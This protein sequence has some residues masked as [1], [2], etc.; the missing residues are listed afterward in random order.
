MERERERERECSRAGERANV[1][2]GKLWLTRHKHKSSARSDNER[3]DSENETD[4]IW[5]SE[6]RS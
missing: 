1:N 5:G 3:L 4:S 6:S 2:G